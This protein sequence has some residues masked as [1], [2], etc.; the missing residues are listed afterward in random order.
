M[1]QADEEVQPVDPGKALV[2]RPV[3]GPVD[4]WADLRPAYRWVRRGRPVPVAALILIAAQ[5]AWRAQL[6]GH[7]YFYRDDFFALDL[8]RRS[9]FSWH[10]LTYVGPGHLVVTER[11][12]AWVQARLSLYSWGLAS[13]VV[14]ALLAAC[15]LAAFVA[16]RTLFGER[17]RS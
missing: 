7:L 17:R 9:A 2:R 16:L 11:A 8:A 13:A 6:L 15:G 3:A 4:A 1:S 14:L 12:I 5:V 10:Y